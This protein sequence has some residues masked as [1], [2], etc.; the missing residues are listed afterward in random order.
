MLVGTA[1][2]RST[3]YRHVAGWILY[4]PWLNQ[5]GGMHSLVQVCYCQLSYGSKPWVKTSSEYLDD[6]AWVC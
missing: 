6:N 3:P 4:P 1:G 2:T 5:H